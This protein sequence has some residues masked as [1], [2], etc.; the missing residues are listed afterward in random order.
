MNEIQ[1]IAVI[2]QHFNLQ[3]I[4]I[5][6]ISTVPDSYP[7]Q[8]NTGNKHPMPCMLHCT[9][10][11]VHDVHVKVILDAFILCTARELR[12]VSKSTYYVTVKYVSCRN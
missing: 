7:I 10:R 6:Y 4:L 12:R 3:H 9:P 1:F 8:L 11:A 2:N 5:N